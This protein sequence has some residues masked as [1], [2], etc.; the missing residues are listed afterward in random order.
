LSDD[1]ENPTGKASVEQFMGYERRPSVEP[2]PEAPPVYS[3]ADAVQ[4]AANAHT[5]AREAT[6][7]PPL[8]EIGYIEGLES[9][10]RPSTSVEDAAKALSK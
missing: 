5:R 6:T 2:E 10:K 7:E 9:G 4:D 3:G 1:T 8:D